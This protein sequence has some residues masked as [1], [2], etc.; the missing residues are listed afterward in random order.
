MK[1]LKIE[2]ARTQI[3]D[4]KLACIAKGI[5]VPSLNLTESGDHWFVT[6]YKPTNENERDLI[7]S[8]NLW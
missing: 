3:E 2:I 1:S 6:N 4:Y 7:Q 5:R 8:V